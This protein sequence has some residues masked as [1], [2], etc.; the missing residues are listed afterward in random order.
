MGQPGRS[1]PAS[2]GDLE[3]TAVRSE[4]QLQLLLPLLR[5]YCDFYQVFPDDASLLGLGRALIADPVREGVQLLA[6]RDGRAVGFATLYW[7]WATT[8]AGRIGILNDLFVVD[9]ARGGGAGAAVLEACRQRCHEQGALRLVWQT[10]P[11]NIRAQALYERIGA[12]RESWIDY[13]IAT[14]G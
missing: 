12:V 6:T 9:D 3:I 8:I 13:W 14:D 7:T 5:A 1:Q 2:P 4:A 10:A 11:D